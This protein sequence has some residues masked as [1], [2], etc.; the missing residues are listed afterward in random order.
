MLHPQ[1]RAPLRA[2]KYRKRNAE[3]QNW[4][5]AHPGRAAYIDYEVPPSPR[6][7]PPTPNT[8][9]PA[10]CSPVQVHTKLVSPSSTAYPRAEGA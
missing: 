7:P 1:V 10:T 9:R 8:K 2:A 3:M 5:V 6:D 4:V